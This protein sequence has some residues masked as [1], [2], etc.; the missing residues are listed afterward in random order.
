MA[1]KPLETGAP[2]ASAAKKTA[3]R[4]TA[5]K[6]TASTTKK[7]A[8]GEKKPAADAAPV[9]APTTKIKTVKSATKTTGRTKTAKTAKKAADKKV[10]AAEQAAPSVTAAP[11]APVEKAPAPESSPKPQASAPVKVKRESFRP[12]RNPEQQERH[13]QHGGDVFAQP[14]T[15]GG[16]SEVSFN[17]RKRRR[18]NKKGS[19]SDDRQP[20]QDSVSYKQLDGK[21][22]AA[23]AWKMFLA[24]VSEEGLALMD[25]QTARE[26]A[27]RAFRCAEFFMMEECRRK[28]Q[29]A[30]SHQQE[31]AASPEEE[32]DSEEDSGEE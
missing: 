3:V 28:A 20:M 17:K 1:K 31:K 5:A 18:R 32:R 12:N 29:K 22:V 27:R 30:I 24:E 16:A 19:G 7:A 13:E 4:R 21:K 15:V 23:R 14:E 10:P 25:D 6:K 11:A 9:E 8:E 2:E 26:A